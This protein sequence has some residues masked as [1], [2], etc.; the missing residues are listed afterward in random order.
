MVGV[1]FRTLHL[2]VLRS[3]AWGLAWATKILTDPFHNVANYW[4][5]PLALLRG[6]RLDPLMD[7]D[8]P[9]ASAG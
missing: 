5:S 8:H 1:C 6:Q 7:D 2:F 9:I 3:P 4:R